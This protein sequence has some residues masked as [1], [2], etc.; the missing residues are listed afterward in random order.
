MSL[1]N[2]VGLFGFIFTIFELDKAK[3]VVLVFLDELN[4]IANDLPQGI[5]YRVRCI[6]LVNL[7]YFS[8]L[9]E[10]L[11]DSDRL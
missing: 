1:Y 10:I 11:W 8:L 5:C 6:N 4:R 3:E 9:F 7:P 2:D